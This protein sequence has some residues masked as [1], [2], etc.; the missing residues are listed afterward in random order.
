MT[1]SLL[2]IIGD[3]LVVQLVKNLPAMQ[4]TSILSL[5]WEDPREKERLPT[6]VFWPR[7]FHGLYSPWGRKEANTTKRLSLSVTVISDSLPPHEPQPA[8]PPCPS[9][10]PGIY[11]NSCPLSQGCHTTISSFVV[12]FSSCPLF[13]SIRSFQMSQLF[14]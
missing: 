4:E 11:P 7:E 1:F 12:P 13:P 2:I 6:P 3:S 14:A 5:G 8:R 10:T 9:P